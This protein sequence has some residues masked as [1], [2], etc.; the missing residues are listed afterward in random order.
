M[1]YISAY[2]LLMKKNGAPPSMKDMLIFYQ[3]NDI[4]VKDP[5]KLERFMDKRASGD[6]DSI[7]SSEVKV[8]SI[9]KEK[10]ITQLRVVLEEPQDGEIVIPTG[11]IFD[12][13]DGY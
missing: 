1:I 13:D 8:F 7:L 10:T 2:A 12:A 11:G 9:K 3:E 5:E 6:M 4:E